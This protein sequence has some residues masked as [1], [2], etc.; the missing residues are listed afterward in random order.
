[1]KHR[2][3]LSFLLVGLLV[4]SVIPFLPFALA[5]PVI[6]PTTSSAVSIQN[7]DSFAVSCPVAGQSFTITTPSGLSSTAIARN[8]LCTSTTP[9]PTG[10]CGAVNPEPLISST[11]GWTVFNFAQTPTTGSNFPDWTLLTDPGPIGSPADG[12]WSISFREEAN[13]LVNFGVCLSVHSKTMLLADSTSNGAYTCFYNERSASS[14]YVNTDCATTTN[15]VND[16]N[17]FVFF[18]DQV[19]GADPN[20]EPFTEQATV[21]CGPPPVMTMNGIWI[22]GASQTGN[23]FVRFASIQGTPPIGTTDLRT[24]PGVT[25]STL[26]DAG[27]ASSGSNTATVFYD[28]AAGNSYQFLARAGSSGAE[29]LG[30]ILFEP[31]AQC[32]PAVLG[33]TVPNLEPDG[34]TLDADAG[35]NGDDIE[36]GGVYIGTL[37]THTITVFIESDPSDATVITIP[38][39]AM[40]VDVGVGVEI[41]HKNVVLPPGPYFVVGIVTVILTGVQVAIATDSVT[42]AAGACGNTIVDVLTINSHTD[43]VNQR[44]NANLT[45]IEG[46]VNET[47]EHADYIMTQNNKTLLHI[48][49]VGSYVNQTHN[50]LSIIGVEV[51]ETEAHADDLLAQVILLRADMNETETHADDLLAQ[52]VAARGDIN[53][54]RI[55]VDEIEVHA[56]DLLAQL[57]ATRADINATRVQVDEIEA[58]ADDLLAQQI[59]GSAR[60]NT[61]RGILIQLLGEHRQSWAAANASF[62]DLDHHAHLIGNYANDTHNALTIIG[63][64]VNETE[65]HADDLLVQLAATRSDI[66]ATRAQVDETEAHTDDILAQQ[67]AQRSQDNAT[68]SLILAGIAD[69]DHH[70]HLLGNY[71]N[72]TTAGGTTSASLIRAMWTTLNETEEHADYIMT[73]E[74]V[75]VGTVRDAWAAANASFGDL[76]HH[77]HLIGGYVNATGAQILT[78][79]SNINSTFI[80]NITTDTG[81]FGLTALPGLSDSD[82]TAVLVMLALL[83]FAFWNGFLFTG[84]MTLAS[85]IR[86]FYFNFPFSFKVLFLFVLIGLVLDLV[87]DWMLKRANLKRDRRTAPQQAGSANQQ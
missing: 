48:D 12:T 82:T 86:P 41:Y 73:Q 31:Q 5:A 69:L 34:F 50:A 2:R 59:A 61:T 23:T 1:M 20:P 55:Q 15:S 3:L 40:N 30:A 56:D 79:I 87:V 62:G 77:A 49:Q 60:D 38:Q 17:N 57:A 14:S 24:Q 18:S 4:A 75:T 32:S 45:R 54:T 63:I 10:T 66:N 21:A 39:S 16:P 78:A 46:T 28:T 11:T 83:I 42:V 72:E 71:I 84:I 65:A 81:L 47:E 25:L 9:I 37:A 51:N 35:C 76:D 19:G 43:L 80:G 33:L 58:H 26:T 36:F 64:E 53:A 6:L 7:T 13:T 68:F 44:L 8:P 67:A 29:Q 27:A 22:R 85:L 52:L 70:A 74:N